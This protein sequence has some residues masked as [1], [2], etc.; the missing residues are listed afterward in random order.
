[1]IMKTYFISPIMLLAVIFSCSSNKRITVSSPDKTIRFELYSDKKTGEISFTAEAGGKKILLPSSFDIEIKEGDLNNEMRILKVEKE[2]VSHTWINNF[3]ERKEIPD[4]YNQAKVFIKSNDLEYNLILRVYNEGAAFT[5]EFPRQEGHDSLIITDEKIVFRFPGDYMAWSAPRAQALYSHVQLSKIDMGAER[6]LV[7]EID[8]TLTIALTEA[9]L[10]D[11]ARMKFEPDPSAG[12]AI[13]TRLGSE[14]NKSLPF[15]SP[16]RVIMIGR[17]PGDLLEKNYLILNLNDPSE[18]ED[19]S[20][21]TPGKV[22]REVSLS[23]IGG[24]AAVDF[25]SAHNMQY[26]E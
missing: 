15:Q 9:K 3:G 12:I 11:Y 25:V 24:K 13:R 5:Y 17:N 16:W 19:I 14:V 6:P 7:I 8:S 21:I 18:I 4:N 20:W 22:L 2:S 1:M 23:T 10:V 26:L